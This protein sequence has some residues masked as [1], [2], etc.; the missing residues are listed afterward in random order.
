MVYV[1][2][3]IYSI[4]HEQGRAGILGAEMSEEMFQIPLNLLMVISAEHTRGYG[5]H[6]TWSGEV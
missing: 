5:I 1:Y 6:L 3:Y 4:P 2:V